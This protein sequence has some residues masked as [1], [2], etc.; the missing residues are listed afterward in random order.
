MAKHVADSD[1]VAYPGIGEREARINAADRGVPGGHAVANDSSDERGGNR[2]GKRGNLEDGLRRDGL[3][4]PK[5]AYAETPLVD[6]LVGV[7]YCHC[8]ARDT[9][10]CHT[11]LDQAV[12][13]IE[14]GLDLGCRDLR[15]T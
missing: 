13:A 12:E 3:G 6:H 8:H 14:R 7:N 2:F 4:L 1:L 9:S 15:V 5:L 11:V 10:L